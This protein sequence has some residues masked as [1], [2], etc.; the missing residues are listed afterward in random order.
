[1]NPNGHIPG[2]H[3]PGTQTPIGY[4]VEAAQFSASVNSQR[5]PPPPPNPLVE[6]RRRRD[7]AWRRQHP[8]L[9]IAHAVGQLAAVLSAGGPPTTPDVAVMNLTN[10]TWSK[11]R[12]GG[13]PMRDE[14]SDPNVQIAIAAAE[15]Q[16]WDPVCE[17]YHTYRV[18]YFVNSQGDLFRRTEGGRGAPRRVDG[19][20]G[21]RT[22]R[23]TPSL[24]GSRTT[25]P[26]TASLL[27]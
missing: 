23:L 22:R 17:M 5:P 2:Y 26:S 24:Q 15:E 1:M 21:V 8:R 4:A 6:G 10:R 14:G 12:V 3:V 18:N 9:V 20:E 11:R 27:R 16:V 19:E 7:I 13:A 25:E